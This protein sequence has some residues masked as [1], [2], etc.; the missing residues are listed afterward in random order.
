MSNPP[1]SK[2]RDVVRHLI[3]HFLDVTGDTLRSLFSPGNAASVGPVS[4]MGA[5]IAG[6]FFLPPLDL[7]SWVVA[8]MLADYTLGMA[9]AAKNRT[10]DWNR[11]YDGGLGKVIRAWLLVPALMLDNIVLRLV[12]T[13]PH[14]EVNVIMEAG[15]LPFTTMAIVYL[16]S[17]ELVSM[18]DNISLATGASGVPAFMRSGVDWLRKKMGESEAEQQ[19]R[20]EER[21]DE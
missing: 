19:E 16:I 11:L 20:A 14:P 5:Y 7:L 4:A 9:V 12:G 13:L 3:V 6:L 2:A 1:T 10:W 15:A 21:P 18:L 8:A 17:A